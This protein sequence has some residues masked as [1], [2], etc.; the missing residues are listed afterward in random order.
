MDSSFLALDIGERRIGVAVAN[1]IARVAR[2]LATLDNDELFAQR[3]R[4]LIT[5]YQP[6]VVVVGLPRGL[7]GQDT[8]QT[9][10]VKE[11]VKG[12]NLAV[13][14]I[15][16][17]EALTSVRAKEILEDSGRSFKKEAIDAL[18]ASI[19]L[20]DYLIGVTDGL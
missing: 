10:Y 3:F 12:L 9:D 7:D 6:K 4:E 16:Q 5:E 8:A 2:P 1:S 20:E 14:P 13:A 15:F 19:I 18:A 11:F 17:D